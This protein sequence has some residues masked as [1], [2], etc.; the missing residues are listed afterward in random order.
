MFAGFVA[1]IVVIRM[2]NRET[3]LILPE[4]RDQ[5]ATERADRENNAYYVLEEAQAMLPP[6]PGAVS[7]E[8]RQ[9]ARPGPVLQSGKYSYSTLLGIPYPPDHP[10]LLKYIEDSQGAIAKAR[11]AVTR[12]YF[13]NQKP[14]SHWILRRRIPDNI[15]FNYL[16]TVWFAYAEAQMRFWG[17]VE[18]GIA[19]LSDLWTVF[20]KLDTEPLLIQARWQYMP[21]N[22]DFFKMLQRLI[23]ETEDPAT[24]DALD[25]FL[26]SV[27]P[28]YPDLAEIFEAHARALD[29]TLLVEQ[30]LTSYDMEVH[31][32]FD[33]RFELYQLQLV[34]L[35]YAK[36][37]NYFSDGEH[38]KPGAFV[39]W[40]ET[41]DWDTIPWSDYMD[42]HVT[43]QLQ[44]E[45]RRAWIAIDAP[46][47]TQIAIALQR[48]FLEH[49]RYPQSLD[50]LVP[51]HIPAIPE[52]LL[53][54]DPWIYEG[55]SP[56]DPDPF[57]TL[58]GA[59]APRYGSWDRRD[60]TIPLEFVGL[61]D[62]K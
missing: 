10:H 20:S 6:K 1:L 47:A 17:D 19:T 33:D 23:R 54:S 26:E 3:V 44:E 8:E 2:T 30:I 7:G 16:F 57:F 50:E 38:L 55:A 40:L 9:A 42:I 58:H 27:T 14:V 46:Q 31:L 22:Y 53:S 11:T 49:H 59:Q 21:F 35:F 4:D 56:D 29:D 13:R 18:G 45:L 15:S 37:R 34:A 52:S 24:L 5:I 25:A 28:L 36:H 60:K 39:K 62:Y 51:N 41:N 48:Y 12:P 61:S 32:G 43:L